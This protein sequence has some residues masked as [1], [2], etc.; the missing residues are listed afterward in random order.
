MA[1]KESS[2]NEK[3]SRK[4]QH[5]VNIRKLLQLVQLNDYETAPQF[6]QLSQNLTWDYLFYEHIM[7]ELVKTGKFT[8]I[9]KQS[10]VKFWLN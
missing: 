1:T 10:D 6:I 3:K 8:K 7:Q 9:N 2:Y 4:F 5:L